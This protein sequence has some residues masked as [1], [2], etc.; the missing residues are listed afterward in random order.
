LKSFGMVPP[1]LYVEWSFLASGGLLTAA[2]P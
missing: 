2:E 1:P